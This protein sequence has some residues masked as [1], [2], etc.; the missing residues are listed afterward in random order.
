MDG[1]KNVARNEQAYFIEDLLYHFVEWFKRLWIVAL[2]LA[3]LCSAGL[4]FV[5]YYRFVPSY[6][7]S[8]TFTV[9]VDVRESSTESYNKATASQLAKTFPNILTSSSLNKV[10]CS[11]LGVDSISANISASVLEDT[12]LFTITVV[13]SN[14]QMAYDVLQSVINNY[15]QVAKFVIGSTQLSLI[16][17]SAISTMPTNIPNYTKK[18]IIGALAGAFAGL[19]LIVLLSL[20][21]T[22]VIRGDDI[23]RYFNTVCLGS[24]PDLHIKKRSKELDITPN[25]SDKRINYKFREGL[26]TVR[27]SVVRICKDKGY[28]SIAVT[29]TI[30]G[31]GKS[32]VAINLAEAIALKGYRTC[33]VD[34]DLRIPSV[35]DY[36]DIDEELNSVSD[37]IKGNA[38]L[39]S[40]V[41]ATKMDNFYIAIEKNKNSDASELVGEQRA[42]ELIAN[43]SRIF[44]FVIIDTPP[45]GYLADASVIGDYVDASVYVIAQ[46]MV[47]RR[48]IRGGLATFDN[49][50]ADVIGCVLNRI[51]K[52]MESIGYGKYSYRRYGRYGRYGKKYALSSFGEELNTSLNAN[53]EGVEFEEE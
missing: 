32:V 20:T 51:T 10:I 39:N 31:E 4:S 52:G 40:C 9:N 48:G 1:K 16:D 7:V 5:T 19:M 15:P 35:A 43:L 53:I 22:T 14:A 33:L 50:K 17:T 26:Y 38:E 45:A 25:I 12:N 28:K 8:A 29:S 44:E 11:D 23:I 42:K 36:L 24:I 49:L 21:T 30:S 47:S 2:V 37:Y 6:S 46:D 18:A 13:D 27:N 34:F 3:V 41:Y